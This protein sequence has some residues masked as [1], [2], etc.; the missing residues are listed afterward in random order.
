M[1]LSAHHELV[2]SALAV[3]AAHEINLIYKLTCKDWDGM[4][5]TPASPNPT[6]VMNALGAMHQNT[7]CW[8]SMPR[9]HYPNHILKN[10]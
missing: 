4:L 10:S 6:D 5:F 9:G 8:K 2:I 3:K 7:V 1:Y